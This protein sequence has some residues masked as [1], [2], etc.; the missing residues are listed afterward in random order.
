[1][2]QVFITVFKWEKQVKGAVLSQRRNCRNKHF[3][4]F[5]S[6][7]FCYIYS[8]DVQTF[9]HFSQNCQDKRS[10][11]KNNQ[12]NKSKIKRLFCVFYKVFVNKTQWWEK[13]GKWSSFHSSSWRNFLF[14][15]SVL[16]S[17]WYSVIFISNFKLFSNSE[18]R[19][20]RSC[21]YKSQQTL[22]KL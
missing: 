20:Y 8:S 19:K 1:M 15:T 17:F 9:C 12:A 22:C 3:K 2:L 21:F 6:P 4:S 18:F 11:K 5:H 13:K 16:I 7:G 10:W 14:L